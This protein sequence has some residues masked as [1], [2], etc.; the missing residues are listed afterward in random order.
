M[1]CSALS[2]EARVTL[3][4][5]WLT[6]LTPI[7]GAITASAAIDLEDRNLYPFRSVIT[8]DNRS[9]FMLA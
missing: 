8:R 7:S 5:Y 9:A 2:S 4:N 3:G 6:A 1:A